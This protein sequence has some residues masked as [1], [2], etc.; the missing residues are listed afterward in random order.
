[1]RWAEYVY[2]SMYTSSRDSIPVSHIKLYAKDELWVASGS[3]GTPKRKR[4]WRKNELRISA[5][6]LTHSVA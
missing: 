2:L 6:A 3:I 5:T 1:M 4:C